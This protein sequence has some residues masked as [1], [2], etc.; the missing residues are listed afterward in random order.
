M[1]RR[2]AKVTDSQLEP[3][4]TQ[5]LSAYE[6]QRESNIRSNQ[7]VLE[8]LGL[9]TP[10]TSQLL[11][12]NSRPRSIQHCYAK[13]PPK[14]TANP[15]PHHAAPA[16]TIAPPLPRAQS[17]AQAPHPQEA[18]PFFHPQPQPQPLSSE[19][20]SPSLKASSFSWPARGGASWAREPEEQ[21]QGGD[22][23]TQPMPWAA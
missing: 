5:G 15:K 21:E 18:Q 14:A 19:T 7:A 6:L 9:T 2:S 4:A 23:E 8:S 22:K 3:A 17:P 20:Q 12:P 16:Q 11:G 10:L 13:P 1:I